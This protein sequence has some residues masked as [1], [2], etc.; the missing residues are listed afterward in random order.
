MIMIKN[1]DNENDNKGDDGDGDD[2]IRMMMLTMMRTM[3]LK[4]YTAQNSFVAAITNTIPFTT[5]LASLSL[6]NNRL[7][8]EVR[9]SGSHCE[10]R[11]VHRA[12]GQLRQCRC[13]GHSQPE[14]APYIQQLVQH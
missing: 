3:N 8:N 7:Y 4:I 6:R 9:S 1:N 13:I 14:H 11:G 10:H 12:P 5:T 2:V